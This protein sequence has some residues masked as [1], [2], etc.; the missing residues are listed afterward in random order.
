MKTSRLSLL[1]SFSMVANVF[2]S[3][4]PNILFITADDMNWDSLGCY[5]SQV[6]EISPH[7]DS[8]AERGMRFQHAFIN[9][10]A[11][12]PSR[13]VMQTGRYPH[14][15]GVRGFY[16]V[17]FPEKTLPEALRG[18]GYFTGIAQKVPDSTPTNDYD[19]YWNYHRGFP[20][21]RDRTPSTYAE[22]FEAILER[23][24]SAGKP[25]YAVINVTDPHLPFFGGPKTKEGNWDRTPPTR[26][27]GPEEVPIPG[28]LPQDGAFAQEV[29]DY[30]S[31]V[32]GGDD[33][34]GAVLD[35][36]A[37]HGIEGETIVIFLSDHGMSFPFA[38]SN[39]YPEGVRVP[40]IVAWPGVSKGGQLDTEHMISAID[41]M[42]T[43]LDM[44]GVQL[45]DGLEGRTT[46]PL[47]RG[48][49]QEGRNRIFVEMNEN[50][51]ADVRP[52]RGIFSKDFVY[53][54]SPWSD[55][56]RVSLFES[57]WY[58]SYATFAQLAKG[59]SEV[60][61]RFDFLR[62]RTV[63][64]LYNYTS[65]PYALNNLIDNPHYAGVLEDLRNELEAQMAQTGDYVL[66][67]F[68]SRGDSKALHRFMAEED[69]K[70]LERSKSVEWKRW[71]NRSGE[72]GGRTRYFDPVNG[73]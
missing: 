27:Y 9:S 69:A 7:I 61:K 46:V 43:V 19:R 65:D 41:F 16:S 42:P 55:G 8:L 39:L 70:A 12:T 20:P 24:N 50:P 25:F 44:A 57:R 10:P 11:C 26:I 72:T 18:A 54:F 67:A 40:W 5:G 35:V 52:A 73:N 3:E 56:E 4:Q 6:D 36:L 29:A 49:A 33:C 15:S 30:Y 45:P 21:E 53:I 38:K 32:R 28:F 13:N 63:E 66:P 60:A 68:K 64:E 58:R 71:R 37:N 34:V 62:Y 2:A 14:S 23:A 59:D 17:A 51:N 1:A 31:S 48:E 47:I 22:A